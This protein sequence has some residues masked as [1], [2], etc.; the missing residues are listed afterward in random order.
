[1]LELLKAIAGSYQPG[2]M[3]IKLTHQFNEGLSGFTL[4]QLG[5]FLHEYIHYLQN[6]STPWGLYMSMVQ[7][8]TIAKTY[9]HIKSS[10]D[11]I[12][13]PFKASTP[14][15]E[16]QWAIINV[17]R[18]HYPFDDEYKYKCQIIDKNKK[19]IIRRNIEHIG[20]KKYPKISLDI[21]F[22]DGALRTIDLGALIINESMAAMYQMMIDPHATHE[23][24]DMPYNLIQI[25]C[26]QYFPNI[27][28]DRKKLIS[29]CYI[30]LFSMSPAEILLDQMN[31]ASENPD[32]S[33][34]D[35]FDEFIDSSIIYDN[36]G[37]KSNIA[38][39][40]DDLI[41]RFKLILTQLLNCELDYIADIL[42]KVRISK[43]LIPLL[44]IIYNEGLNPKLIEEMINVLDVPFTYNENGEHFLPKSIKEPSENASDMLVL[45]AN[46]ALYNYLVYPNEYRCCPLKFMC[47]QSSPIIEKDE[48]YDFPWLG[49]K[50]PITGLCEYIGLK[51]KSFKWKY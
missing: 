14:E 28:N 39:F 45:I 7:Y 47:M 24:N 17:G 34:V 48:C 32:I 36:R 41:E 44:N 26:E 2:F 8:K 40:M 13:L 5:V 11:V 42:D 22:A 20:E 15:L 23:N 4:Q 37:R 18:G 1:M 6:I 50:C 25:L 19:I 46:S 30:S 16:R 12:E 43:R 49:E 35:L 10:T 33:G 3:Q 31:Y 29:I 51:N 38:D 9:A 21:S 27:A